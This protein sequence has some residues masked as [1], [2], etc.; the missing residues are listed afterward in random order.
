[1]VYLNDNEIVSLGDGEYLAGTDGD[2]DEPH[3]RAA[4]AALGL[5]RLGDMDAVADT[6]D[7]IRFACGASHD[8]AVGLLLTRALNVRAAIR[9]VE[10]R[11]TRGV[12]AAPSAQ[13]D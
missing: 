3:R 8:A 7:R 2:E 12:L 1:M 10:E 9:E 6:S 5:V 11:S 4:V 13:S